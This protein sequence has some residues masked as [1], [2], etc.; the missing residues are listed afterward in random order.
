M[1]FLRHI[2][3][4]QNYFDGIFFSTHVVG[5]LFTNCLD[6]KNDSLQKQLF[7]VLCEEQ[8]RDM[9]D[10]S[11]LIASIVPGVCKQACKNP[12]TD[13]KLHALYT[14]SLLMPRLDQAFVAANILPSLKYITETDKNPQVSVVVIGMYAGISDTLGTDYIG[15]NILPTL[16]PLLSDK[17]LDAEQF[18]MILY[19]TEPSRTIQKSVCH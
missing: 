2:S 15:S 11:S 4:L 16:L 3:F 7:A 1:A 18:K 14:L 12:E 6:K 8:V 9:V 13:V 10:Q 17:S 19:V 5:S